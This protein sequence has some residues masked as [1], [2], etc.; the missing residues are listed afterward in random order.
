[1]VEEAQQY[2]VSVAAHA[3]TKEGIARA[4]KA[5]AK[6]IEHGRG[7]DEELIDQALAAGVYWCPTMLVREYYESASDKI[8]QQLGLA[9]RKGLPI[10][11][12]TDI[13]S[14]PWTVNQAKELEYYVKK[15]G[16]SPMDAIKSGTST[17][18]ALLNGQEVIGQIKEGFLA[19]IIA[20]AGNPLEDITLLQDVR[21]VMRSGKIYKRP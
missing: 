19:N 3:N 9:Y 16:M 14:L 15:A 6:S 21:F 4:I 5:G 13:G 12:S 20:V 7:F 2:G 17:A 11:L 10:V 18:A 1:M 8:Y